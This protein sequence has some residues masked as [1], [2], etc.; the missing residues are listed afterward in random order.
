MATYVNSY[1]IFQVYE[2]H[3]TQ[4]GMLMR[5]KAR[6]PPRNASGTSNAMFDELGERSPMSPLAGMKHTYVRVATFINL[7]NNGKKKN[8]P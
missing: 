7:Y 8:V 4:L 3:I 5:D 6:L 1:N 2:C